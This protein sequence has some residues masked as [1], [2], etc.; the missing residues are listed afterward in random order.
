MRLQLIALVMIPAIARAQGV[1][2]VDLRSSVYQDSDRT[3]IETSSATAG[4][5]PSEKLKLKG[6]YLVDVVSSASVDVISQATQ[7]FDD[8]RHEAS[9]SAAWA[10]GTR[11]LNLAYTYS[12]ENDWWSNTGALSF[13]HDLANHQ[14]TLGVS[15][16]FTHNEIG[17]HGD[18]MF[19]RR[20]DQG[21]GG[22]DL[23]IAPSKRDLV[24]IG[25]T[26]VFL[27]G[28]QASPYRFV[29][30]GSTDPGLR[31]GAWE[32]MPD[33][34]VR[35]AVGLKWNHHAF[36]DSALRTHARFYTDDWGI[37]SGTGGIEW[38]S[39]FGGAELA[40]FVR[41]YVQRGADFYRR[42][43]AQRM[44]YMSADKETSPLA[45]GF[46]GLRFGWR[47]SLRGAIDE[48]RFD[49]SVA[50]FAFAYFDFARLANNV[51]L[52]AQVAF[53]ATF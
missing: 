4:A 22:V 42:T 32:T 37:L 40:P 33:S 30:W 35:H 25:Y 8:I 47:K 36:N 53:G 14:A 21:S 24:S 9:G 34:R 28:Y 13:A 15:A 20:L 46:A 1:A 44:R 11:T 49:A 48:F 19:H 5:S 12:G 26:F 2:D 7:R 16:S 29:F 17:R 45:D 51:G 23:S 27:S 31:L 41:G 3:F 10:D 39:G 6:R 18:A 38:V 50:G 43:Y 52:H